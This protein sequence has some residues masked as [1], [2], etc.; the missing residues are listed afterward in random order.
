M[1]TG[2]PASE[3]TLLDWYAGQETLSDFDHP[4]ENMPVSGAVTLA[5]PQP[6]GGKGWEAH[7]LWNAEW[8][9][10]MKYIRAEAMLAEKARRE[11]QMKSAMEKPGV[12]TAVAAFCRGQESAMNWARREAVVRESSTTD[13][14]PD[15]TKMIEPA[16]GLQVVAHERA[17]ALDRVAELE[18]ANRE[19]VGALEL[20]VRDN[21][22][23][24]LC[25]HEGEDSFGRVMG[26]WGAKAEEK[27]RA[28]ISKHKGAA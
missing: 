12:A 6:D 2:G 8:R 21:A 24:S 27:A 14:S 15:A 11:W 26:T 22:A 3:K 7:F 5:G 19:L 20:L 9:A 1:N 10:K 16:T 28:T 25:M 4:E 23:T 18:A 17:Q 13:H